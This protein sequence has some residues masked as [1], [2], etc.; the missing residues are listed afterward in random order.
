MTSGGLRGCSHE[1]RG[2]WRIIGCC[3]DGIENLSRARVA[4]GK[5]DC[6]LAV[7]RVCLA[8]W[9]PGQPVSAKPHLKPE[10]VIPEHLEAARSNTWRVR[11]DCGADRKR[12]SVRTPCSHRTL[13]ETFESTDGVRTVAKSLSA[14]CPTW[15][16]D[17]EIALC[18]AG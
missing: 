17:S 4:P 8:E 5:R 6:H 18:I 1:R 15:A 7:G 13:A 2:F 10:M 3:D 9:K 12:L 16:S 11:C 14:S